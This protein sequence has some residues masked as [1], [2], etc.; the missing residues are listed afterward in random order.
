MPYGTACQ[1]LRKLILFS[2]VK[3]TGRDECLRCGD[4]I[5]TAEELSIEHRDPWLH[6]D[7]A[8]F[9]DINNISFSHRGCNTR[10]AARVPVAQRGYRTPGCRLCG[11][12]WENV[13]KVKNRQLCVECYN[14]Q[15]RNVMRKR[16]RM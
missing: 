11:Q 3:E 2:L 13:R 16:R 9:W 14:D 6:V 12:P 1:R 15:Q 7:T 10:G 5:L 4:R 8:L